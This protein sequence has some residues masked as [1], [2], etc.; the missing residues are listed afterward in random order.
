MLLVRQTAVSPLSSLPSPILV[1]VISFLF[2]FKNV[3]TLLMVRG[4]G[5]SYYDRTE[6]WREAPITSCKMLAFCFSLPSLTLD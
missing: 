2:E 5:P 6:T 4:P 3:L 1:L